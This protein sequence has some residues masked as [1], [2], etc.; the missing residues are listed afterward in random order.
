MMKQ[1]IE[2]F[3]EMY[4]KRDFN[5]IEPL[6]HALYGKNE[7]PILIG[8]SNGELYFD[9]AGIIKLLN[10]DLQDWG[11]V[12]LN[13]DEMKTHCYGPYQ[14]IH[15][16]ATLKQT[17]E[18]ND[19]TYKRFSSMIQEIK[20]DTQGTNYQKIT[21][22]SQLLTH[23]M[24]D[25][26]QKVREYLLEL[27]IDIITLD[28]MGV[29][30]QFSMPI[31][32]LLPDVRLDDFDTYNQTIYNKELKLI[33]PF[34]QR[35]DKEILINLLKERVKEDKKA[36]QVNIHSKQIVIREFD[37]YMSFIATGYYEKTISL[38]QRLDHLFSHFHE[39]K[40]PKKQLFNIRRDIAQHL[41]HDA[42]GQTMSIHFRVIG[43]AEKTGD[44]YHIHFIKIT[45]PYNI[46]L[47]EK[48]DFASFIE[49]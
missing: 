21:L 46:I 12:L 32:D 44:S 7:L 43:I 29:M 3:K 25:R 41:L 36:T 11:D 48:T 13:I 18:V 34:A 30:L 16:P 8:T 9:K 39:T 14:H 24:S 42:I 38:E 33:E 37:Q 23:L 5:Q 20:N 28:N 1:T 49:K 2:L 27:N 22:I 40:P 45:L 15:I 47:E 17:F 35:L 10:S 19:E 31:D 4:L 26:V 6:Y